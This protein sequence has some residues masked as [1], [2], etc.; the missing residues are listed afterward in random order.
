MGHIHLGV[1]PR[2]R[3]WRAVVDLL[4]GGADDNAVIAASA[5]AAE[6]DLLG[7]AHDPVFVEAVRLLLAVPLAARSEHFGAALRAADLA[8]DDAPGLLDL[9]TAVSARLDQVARKGSGTSDMGELAARA[10]VSTF[11][12]SIGDRL[13]GLFAATPDDVQ[14]AARKLSWSRGIAELSRG[15]FGQLVSASLSSWLDRTLAGHIGPEARFATAARRGGF[16]VALA[17]YASE[18]TRIVQEFSGGWFG[19]TVRDKG[20]IPSADAAQF[21]AVALKKIVAELRRKR[22]AD[23]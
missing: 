20:G 16:D 19:K 14:V 7:A 11:G 1:L 6:R 22:D 9:T 4:A 18:A 12:L 8:I 5:G 3:K 15:F 23:V 13:P 17:Q 10:L 21:G 2:S